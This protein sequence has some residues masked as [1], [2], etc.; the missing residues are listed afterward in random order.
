MCWRLVLQATGKDAVAEPHNMFWERTLI[1]R[2]V[3]CL[4]L[5]R[6]PSQHMLCCAVSPPCLQA[7]AEP[8]T[9]R[10]QYITHSEVPH[11]P[12]AFQLPLPPRLQLM[13]IASITTVPV[14]SGNKVNCNTRVTVV[15]S[16]NGVPI[17]GIQVTVQWSTTPA[18]NNFPYL[19]TSTSSTNIAAFRSVNLPL[20][21]GNTCTASVT[22]VVAAGFTLD[23]A[24]PLV[25][26]TRSW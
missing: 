25:G 10:A 7:I 6:R 23:P 19:A 9:R 8:S 5:S 20:A 1:C 24:A 12:F 3:C 21:T 15:R 17:P 16:D 26:P 22:A 2:T 13:T 4:V 14:P 18:K 11:T